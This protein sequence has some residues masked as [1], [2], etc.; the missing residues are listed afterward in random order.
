M[1][2]PAGKVNAEKVKRFINEKLKSKYL[3]CKKYKTKN[4][5][6]QNQISKLQDQ[7]SISSSGDDN[8]NNIT[9]LNN[10]NNNNNS[11]NNTNE[12]NNNDN[13]ESY[14][15]IDL[16]QLKIQNAQYNFTIL[17]RNKELLKLKMNTGKTVQ[18]LNNYK[19]RL[20][21]EIKKTKI[22][23]SNIFDRQSL[24]DKLSQELYYIEL[25]TNKQN[26]LYITTK[27]KLA[28]ADLPQIMDYVN[29]KA[30][31]YDLESTLKTWKRKVQIAG[32]SKK[33][34]KK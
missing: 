12:S 13:S 18:M 16:E 28:N 33:Q 19:Q 10:N 3:M 29:Q 8:T 4:Q 11:N 17:E 21:D 30:N 31:Q 2:R 24:I 7:L 23:E 9:G 34:Q 5:Q 20:N 15:T 22:L 27:Q 26:K 6:L 1:I 32:L 25:E 14:H